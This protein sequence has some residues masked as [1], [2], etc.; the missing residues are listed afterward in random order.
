[1][2]KEDRRLP[3]YFNLK[4]SRRSV[5]LKFITCRPPNNESTPTSVLNEIICIRD[6]IAKQYKY[7]KSIHCTPSSVFVAIHLPKAFKVV[8]KPTQLRKSPSELCP[9]SIS[10]NSKKI[11]ESVEKEFGE[12]HAAFYL[13]WAIKKS[14]TKKR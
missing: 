10:N 6:D 9:R 14:E 11:L 3:I 8:K 13:N 2:F 7:E 12:E 4:E 1:M 5:E